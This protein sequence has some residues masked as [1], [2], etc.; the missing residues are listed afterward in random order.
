MV[1]GVFIMKNYFEKIKI[2][3]F[4]S[5][6]LISLPSFIVDNTERFEPESEPHGN[7]TLFWSIL[8]A[9]VKSLYCTAFLQN[10][11]CR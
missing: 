7:A 1:D 10:H 6:Y 9:V 3:P 2:L 5:K 8:S 4:I 11:C